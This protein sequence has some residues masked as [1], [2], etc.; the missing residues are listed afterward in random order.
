MCGMLKFYWFDMLWNLSMYVN[1]SNF[2]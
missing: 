2:Y 1:I